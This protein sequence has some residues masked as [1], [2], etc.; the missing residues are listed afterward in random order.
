MGCTGLKNRRR[1]RVNTAQCLVISFIVE[2][3]SRWG[4]DFV[5]SWEWKVLRTPVTS[6]L[7]SSCRCRKGAYIGGACALWSSIIKCSSGVKL[8]V[9]GALWWDLEIWIC[10]WILCGR[11][12][13]EE[14]CV[15]LG[16]L[17]FIL[18]Q[19][20]CGV[21]GNN[22]TRVNAWNSI[23]SI[24]WLGSVFFGAFRW[25]WDVGRGEFLLFPFA[26]WNSLCQG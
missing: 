8:G 7:C 1:S 19:W 10:C 21:S 3:I 17:H 6:D 2:M 5:T 22:F 20:I 25:K 16:A 11:Q 23:A 24:V 12:S 14:G 4:F 9:L 13:W 18:C 26:A 15:D